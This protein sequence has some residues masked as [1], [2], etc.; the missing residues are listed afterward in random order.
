MSYFDQHVHTH[1]SFDSQAQMRD[2]LTQTCLPFVTTEHLEMSNPDDQQRDDAPDY[3]AYIAEQAALAQT[4]GNELLRGIEVGYYEPRL[5]AI[6]AYLAAGD[7]DITLL[8]FHHDGTYDYQNEYFRALDPQTQVVSYYERMLA[9][10]QKFHDADV[11]AHFDYGLRVLDVTPAQLAAWAGPL[12]EQIFALAVQYQLAFELNTKSMYRWHNLAL[13]EY[14]L[15]LY[16]AAGG[17]LFTIGSD[18]HTGDAFRNHF[19]NAQAL[20]KHNG[21]DK[22]AVYRQH[23][24]QLVEF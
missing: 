19:N 14:A 5:D 23:N 8:S 13:Y 17:T 20:L 7:Y 15:P 9:G 3:A 4:C 2:Y 18:A 1:Y 10:L 16:R 11:L 6:R 12:L 22:L 24:A 21:V